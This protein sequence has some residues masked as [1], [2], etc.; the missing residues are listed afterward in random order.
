[1]GFIARAQHTGTDKLTAYEI[2]PQR[3]PVSMPI[4]KIRAEKCATERPY[5]RTTAANEKR[6]TCPAPHSIRLKIDA[7][8]NK[9]TIDTSTDDALNSKNKI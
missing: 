1:M 3:R 4:P 5:R 2:Q 6:R 9:G 7:H 8:Q